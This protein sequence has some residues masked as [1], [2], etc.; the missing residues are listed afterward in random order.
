MGNDKT[1][2]FVSL[3]AQ[4]IR[5]A[6]CAILKRGCTEIRLDGPGQ[7]DRLHML[8]EAAVNGSTQEE[9]LAR[10]AEGERDEALQLI[11][12]L[13]VKNILVPMDSAYQTQEAPENPLDIFWWHFAPE[14]RA[15]TSRLRSRRIVV[16][17]VNSVSNRL[18]TGL[19]LS[20]F[21]DVTTVEYP[22][23]VASQPRSRGNAAD[24][25]GPCHCQPPLPYE[26][27]IEKV[28]WDQVDCLIATSDVGGR[29]LLRQWN[30][31][32]IRHHR[33]FLPVIL[34]NAIGYVG[35]FVVPGETACYECLVSRENSHLDDPVV[36]R[37][38]ERSA[39]DGPRIAAFHPLM[40]SVL[41]DIAAFE[42]MRW[43]S[44]VA[45]LRQFNT[46]IEVNLLASR[47]TTRKV[48]RIPRCLVCSNLRV[49]PSVSVRKDSID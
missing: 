20:G 46:L 49:Q 21:E 3:P 39:F 26:T 5:M 9:I 45:P 35:P 11:E 34:Q 36:R 43:C 44:E 48:L 10:F 17:G 47:M 18:S 13:R 8:L 19:A 12:L 29:D 38:V 23:R 15:I 1:V 37:A 25:G 32:A 2:R 27:W 42:M 22:D 16:L 31:L 28:D 41:G 6:D 4:V 7:A 14:A 24:L 40:T 33:H 30:E